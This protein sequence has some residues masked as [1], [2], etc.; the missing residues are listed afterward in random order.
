MRNKKL[1]MKLGQLQEKTSKASLQVSADLSND[2]KSII[3][4]TNQRKIYAS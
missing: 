3:L 4:E 2:C 1:K